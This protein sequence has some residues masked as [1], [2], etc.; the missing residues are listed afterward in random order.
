[1]AILNPLDTAYYTTLTTPAWTP[2]AA[3][4]YRL[5]YKAVSDSI[6]ATAP[7]AVDTFDFFVGD[8][9]SIDDGSVGNYFGS[10]TGTNEMIAFGVMY[11]LENEDTAGAAGFVHLQGM[12][13]EMSCLTDS[14]A[15]MEIAIYDTAGFVF[16]TGFP[17]GASPIFTKVF[18]FDGSVPCNL[19]N[20]SLENAQGEP[21]VLPVGTYFVVSSLFPNAT[22]GVIR[23]ANSATWNQPGASSVFQNGNGDWFSGFSNSTT[24]EAPHY[25]LK[26]ADP[27]SIS[28]RENEMADFS[29]YPN[30]TTGQGLIEFSEAG[31]YKIAV[32]TMLGKTVY[33]R[34]VTVNANEKA[35]IDLGDLANGVYLLSLSNSEGATK[36]VRLTL[37]N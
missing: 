3:G 29:V 6:P 28:L 21:L 16:N 8:S 26:I 17:G 24:F 35:Q 2:T 12:E 37:K 1:V 33:Q 31:Q 13:M 18:T 36:T 10:N 27:S 23:F 22:D 30:P 4:D 15:D 20:F 19:V 11:S 32:H 9:Y 7:T 25:R 14:T 5:V 34:A